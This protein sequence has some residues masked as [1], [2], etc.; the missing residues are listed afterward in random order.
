MI[1]I[2]QGGGRLLVGAL[3]AMLIAACGGSSPSSS[4]STPSPT[5]APT[6]VTRTDSAHGTFL[7]DA[8]NQMTLYTFTHDTPGVSNCSG[9]CLAV[10]PALT[11]PAGAPVKGG[12][13][14]TGQFATITRADGPLQ[15]TYQGLPLYFFHKDVAVGDV[16]GVYPSWVLAKP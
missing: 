10:W 1:K 5:T 14:V 6:V 13:G 11:V 9:Q 4:A 15:V 12:A 8:T 3:T 16:T 7:V 2:S